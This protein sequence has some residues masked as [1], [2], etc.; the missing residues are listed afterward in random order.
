MKIPFRWWEAANYLLFRWTV[1]NKNMHFATSRRKIWHTAKIKSKQSQTPWI[2]SLYQLL[3][4][5]EGS[6]WDST[7][8]NVSLHLLRPKTRENRY[9]RKIYLFCKK[10]RL[11]SSISRFVPSAPHW[12]HVWNSHPKNCQLVRLTSQ[13]ATS[14]NHIRQFG[15]V[16]CHLVSSASLNFTM[17]LPEHLKKHQTNRKADMIRILIGGNES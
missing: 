16:L 1:L 2:H 3:H 7:P 15:D 12:F 5:S 4:N 17:I 11:V 9:L 6:S 10:R 14:G 13:C 8:L